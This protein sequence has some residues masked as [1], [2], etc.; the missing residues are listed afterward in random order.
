MPKLT[1]TKVSAL[2]PQGPLLLD[3]ELLD[4]FDDK[5]DKTNPQ[6]QTMDSSDLPSPQVPQGYQ[7]EEEAI[8]F[9]EY[10]VLQV[11]P[12]YR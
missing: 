2:T 4:F 11:A 12:A 9:D 3:M 6:L 8:D 10:A 1:K 7:E 5:D